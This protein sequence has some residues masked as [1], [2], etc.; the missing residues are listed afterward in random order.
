MSSGGR[1][2]TRVRFGRHGELYVV[3]N[4]GLTIDAEGPRE[5]KELTRN[6][7]FYL[8]LYLSFLVCQWLGAK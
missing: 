1:D 3:E 4:R 6:I 8:W 5:A 7:T 2:D